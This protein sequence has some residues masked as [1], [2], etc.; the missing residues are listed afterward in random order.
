[1]NGPERPSTL[2]MARLS[3]GYRLAEVEVRAGYPGNHLSEVERGRRSITAQRLSDVAG[4][5]RLTD[6]ELGRVVRE[7]ARADRARKSGQQTV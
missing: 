2:R 5:L 3:Q 4:V 7:I 6:E 1:M